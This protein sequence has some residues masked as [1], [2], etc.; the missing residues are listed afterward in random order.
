MEEETSTTGLMNFEEIFILTHR[1]DLWKSKSVREV[2]RILNKFR[3]HTARIF[4]SIYI[5]LLNC[6]NTPQIFSC[7]REGMYR[8]KM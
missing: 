5:C 7:V 3:H 2:S 4:A 6:F 1:I 8:C